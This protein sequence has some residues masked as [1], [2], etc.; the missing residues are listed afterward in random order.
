MKD[1]KAFVGIKE[2][3]D[4]KAFVGIKVKDCKCALRGRQARKPAGGREP[5][6]VPRGRDDK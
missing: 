2:V 3:K 1:C 6:R 4:C 5:Q